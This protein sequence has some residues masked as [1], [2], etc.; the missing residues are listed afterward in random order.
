ML[1]QTQSNVTD[2]EKTLAESVKRTGMPIP[3]QETTDW[4]G[5]LEKTLVLAKDMERLKQEYDLLCQRLSEEERHLS[6]CRAGHDEA[7]A[8]VTALLAHAGCPNTEAFRLLESQHQRYEQTLRRRKELESNLAVMAGKQS[9]A[10][11]LR[12]F[13]DEERAMQERK[14]DQLAFD[15]QHVE[16]E[17]SRVMQELATN[18]VRLEQLEGEA[19]LAQ[20]LQHRENLKGDMQ[21]L[22]LQWM[23]LALAQA[24]LKKT[25]EH[26]ERERQPAVLKTA[27][28]IIQRITDGRWQTVSMTLD[29]HRT[30]LMQDASGMSL[31]PEALSR[32]TQEQVFLALRLAYI[33]GHAEFAEPLP[34]L[35][36]EILVNFDRHRAQRTACELARL[37]SGGYGHPHQIFY[38]TCHP[39]TVAFFRT[40]EAAVSLYRVE[41]GGIHQEE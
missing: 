40:Q 32:G 38:F 13:E 28:D 7:R 12:G 25:R 24:L 26:F 39:E 41:N 23:R 17:K 18:E 11:F 21:Q 2:F 14:H 36:D 4:P 35:M 34:L 27:S 37:A 33:I 8:Q 31:P 9:L 10:D 6:V 19:R 22:A 30:L 15:L 3:C 16:Q 20:S 5:L 29:Q 1:A